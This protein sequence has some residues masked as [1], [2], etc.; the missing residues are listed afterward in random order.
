[1]SRNTRGAQSFGNVQEEQKTR[2]RQKKRRQ[3]KMDEMIMQLIQC[4]KSVG[5]LKHF[6][7]SWHTRKC[8]DVQ[9]TAQILFI[10]L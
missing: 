7:F 4:Q 9:F 5:L 6:V 8:K 10:S 2:E 1:M 3:R